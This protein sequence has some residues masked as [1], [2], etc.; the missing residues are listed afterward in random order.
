MICGNLSRFIVCTPG[1]FSAV[2]DLTAAIVRQVV[3][4]VPKWSAIAQLNAAR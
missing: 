1:S 2:L 3:S 4:L